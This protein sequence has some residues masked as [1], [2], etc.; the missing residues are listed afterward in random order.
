[1]ARMVWVTMVLA[2]LASQ[3]LARDIFVNNQGGDD[4][5]EG[6]S[7]TP[8][9]L[10][11]PVKSIRKAMLLAEPGDRVVL[12]NTGTAVSRNDQPFQRPALGL[13]PQPAV[14]HRRP[15]RRA[16]WLGSRAGRRL[17]KLPVGRVF[18]FRPSAHEL[19]A[20]V[21][22]RSAARASAGRAGKWRS[23]PSSSRLS[24]RWQTAGFTSG[25][26]TA[27]CRPTTGSAY[28]RLQTGI[29]LYHVHDVVITNL[30]VEGFQ[31]DG[32][33]AFDGTR[34]CRLV[35][36]VARGNGRSGVTI[37]GC[38]HLE[39]LG[40]LVGDNGWAQLLIEELALASVRDTPLLDNTAPP[41]V[42]HGGRIFI[43]GQPAAGEK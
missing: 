12:T 5:L 2:A 28:C 17:E 23:C 35:Q 40:S 15:R 3:S 42:Q 22:R 9:A 33:N 21:S 19:P 10:L 20:I 27:S 29:T 1:M 7:E 26:K 4:R 31:L 25:R 36:V 32:I 8:A 37:A 43:D 41:I 38:S 18:R 13:R 16:R 11:G 30:T 34:D 14:C 39:V 6:R 24:G